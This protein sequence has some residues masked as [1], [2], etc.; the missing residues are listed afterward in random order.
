LVVNTNIP[1]GS[2]C[3]IGGDSFEYF[4]DYKTGGPITTAPLGIKI[5]SELA[6]RP[7]VILLPSNA[8]VSLTT[9]SGGGG[10]VDA[11]GVSAR[12][13]TFVGNVPLPKGPGTTRRVSWRELLE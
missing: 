4:L 11:D 7:Q 1:G 8:V 5:A 6:T 2:A 3:S 10:S 12:D 9:L 13:P